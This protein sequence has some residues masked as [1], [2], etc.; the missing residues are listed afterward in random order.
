MLAAAFSPATLV[1]QDDSLEIVGE[2]T[3]SMHV[4]CGSCLYSVWSTYPQPCRCVCVSWLF[5]GFGA[6]ALAVQ[7]SVGV[8]LGLWG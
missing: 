4:R 3:A 5:E 6:S 1:V 7:I 2:K 8:G